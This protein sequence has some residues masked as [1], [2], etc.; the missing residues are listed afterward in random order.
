MAEGAVHAGEFDLVPG[1]YL[2]R[3]TSPL[4]Q[5]EERRV[6]VPLPNLNGRDPG[7]PDPALRDPV[8]Q[9]TFVLRPSYAYSFPDPYPIRIRRSRRLPRSATWASWP[10]DPVRDLARI[11][12]RRYLGCDRGGG[13]SVVSL[14]DERER[15]VGLAISRAAARRSGSAAAERRDCSIH[16][17]GPATVDVQNVCVVRGCSTSLAQSALRGWV[18]RRGIGVGQASVA[19]DGRPAA[20]VTRQDGEWSYHFDLNQPAADELV[21][22]TATLSDG[23]SQTVG[24]IPVQRRR[25]TVVPTFAFP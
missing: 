20:T 21:S 6:V 1:V 5:T 25:T 18:H 2:V 19:V 22:V 9:Y 24:G 10:H 7:N 23:T 8:G 16:C 4:Y 17:A 14:P 12:W 13:R 15:P 3:V 11:G